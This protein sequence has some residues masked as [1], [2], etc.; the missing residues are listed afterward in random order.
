MCEKGVLRVSTYVP[1]MCPTC[2]RK[3]EGGGLSP[4]WQVCEGPYMYMYVY[5]KGGGGVILPV[6]GGV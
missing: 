2:M 4:W 5:E 1:V 3:R 6:M